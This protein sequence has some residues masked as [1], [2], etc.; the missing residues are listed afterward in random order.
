[1][2]LLAYLAVENQQPH[3][4]AALVGLLWP[5]MGQAKARKNLRERYRCHSRQSSQPSSPVVTSS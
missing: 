2:A 5:E 3:S 4:R 1:M